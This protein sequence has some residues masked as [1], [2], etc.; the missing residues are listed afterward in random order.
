MNCSVCGRESMW[1]ESIGKS[2][3]CHKCLSKNKLIGKIVRTHINSFHHLLKKTN[4][5]TYKELMS[6]EK[7]D[8][9]QHVK[10]GKV[11]NT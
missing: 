6:L 4:I 3:V 1:L 2:H 8:I 10:L 7:K 5:Q 9:L 11:L